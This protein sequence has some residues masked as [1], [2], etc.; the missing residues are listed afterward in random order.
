MQNEALTF[1]YLIII[2]S[3]LFSKDRGG[4]RESWQLGAL[5]RVGAEAEVPGIREQWLDTATV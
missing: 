3:K 1:D 5:S 4:S 2:I